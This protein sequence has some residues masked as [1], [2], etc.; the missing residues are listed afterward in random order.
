MFPQTLVLAEN[1]ATTSRKAI[2][3]WNSLLNSKGI[4]TQQAIYFYSN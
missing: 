4:I 3:L 1:A 2:L